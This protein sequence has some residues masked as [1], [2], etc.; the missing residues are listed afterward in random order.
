MMR[1]YSRVATTQGATPYIIAIAMM[2]AS[3]TVIATLKDGKRRK[4]GTVM[5][6]NPVRINQR[7]SN[8]VVPS[9]QTARAKTGNAARAKNSM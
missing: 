9:S 4:K 8:G 7:G 1:V 3:P 2:Y 6:A 5:R